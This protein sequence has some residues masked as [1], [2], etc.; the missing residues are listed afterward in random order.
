VKV[1]FEGIYPA[2]VTPFHADGSINWEGLAFNLERYSRLDLAGFVVLGTSGEFPLL[3][4][5]EKL[6]LIEFVRQK[7]GP[8]K[9]VLAGTGM[10]STEETIRLS[11]QAAELGVDGVLVIPPHYFKGSLSDPA[12]ERHYRQVAESLSVPVLLYNMP[13]N[14]GLNLSP[15]LIQRLAE[16]PNIAGLKDSGGNLTQLEEVM[17]G[18]PEGFSVFTGAGSLVFAARVMGAKGAILAVANVLP[19]LCLAILRSLEEGDFV[20]ARDL[21]F[22]L[23]KMNAAVTSRWG[24]AGLKRAVE[25]AGYAAGPPRL[26]LLPFDPSME[27]ELRKILETSAIER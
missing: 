2:L 22:R 23:L 25:L 4:N 3:Q 7:S 17:A 26:P 13:A 27:P 1:P 18:V 9:R 10:E 24:I 19:E 21:Q 14:T 20:S 8:G 5:E 11:K 12:L 15:T 6:C 16:F